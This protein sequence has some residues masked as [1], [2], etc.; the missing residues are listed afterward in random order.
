MVERAP[1]GMQR[2]TMWRETDASGVSGTGL[3]LEGVVFSTGVVVAHWLTPAPRGS[4]SLFDSLEQFLSIH[5][6]PHPGNRTLITFDDGA[7]IDHHDALIV[8]RH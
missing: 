7:T 8:L 3:V 4:I 5:V 6:E 1:S 2:F